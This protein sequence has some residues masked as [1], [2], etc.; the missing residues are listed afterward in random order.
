ML[1]DLKIENLGIIEAQRIRP[2]KGLNIISGETGSG[3]SLLMNALDIVLGARAAPGLVRSG[4]HKAVVEALF[5]P[6]K[7]LQES[8][9]K[10]DPVFQGQY[11]K[12]RREIT[13]EGRSRMFCNDE[14]VTTAYVRS[15]A[16]QL[17][18]IHSQ[19]EQQRILDTDTHLDLVDLFARSKELCQEVGRLYLRYQE[20]RKALGNASIEAEEK[21]QRRSFLHFVLEEI[22]ALDPKAGEYEELCNM[23]AFIHNSG[24]LFQ[25]ICTAY[26]ILREEDFAI[27]DRLS[28]LVDILESHSELLPEAQSYLGQSQEA[29]Y[30]L[31]AVAD[32]LREKK[33]SLQFSPERLESIEERIA[34]YQALHKK[35]GGT[36]QALLHTQDQYMRELS[37]IEMSEEQMEELE[38]ALKQIEEE[39]FLKAE[40]LSRMRR[41]ALPSLEKGLAQE[42]EQLGMP[43]AHITICVKREIH[44]AEDK[45]PAK[46]VDSAISFA[47]QDG[48]TELPSGKCASANKY[49]LHEKG[50]D[51]IEF[52]L[53]ANPGENPKALRKIASGGELSRISLAFK[54][55]FSHEQAQRSLLF[56]EVDAGVGGQVAHRI[57]KRLKDLSQQSQVIVV[58]HLPQIARL[59]D[60]H[61]CVSKQ[62]KEGRAQTQTYRLHSE[63]ERLQ[64]LTRMLGGESSG[65][66]VLEH[67]KELLLQV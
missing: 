59:A 1:L 4:A 5:E 48:D 14:A 8:R 57:A 17:I 51:R 13:F 63:A 52:L 41:A 62:Y 27:L 64:E 12:L 3:K 31:E 40:E 49:F 33:D 29:S 23:R 16:P 30:L 25:D 58:T 47:A 66:K 36:T 43:G 56:D 46:H 20:L 15:L 53:T 28:S 38:A 50:L 22:E 37:S 67:A 42:L 9:G 61:F 21:E 60:Q 24:K 55:I 26:S 18:E 34:A 39:L 44:V 2:G 45:H 10:K 6:G 19:H 65:S 32:F 35:Y 7:E 54:S 11:L